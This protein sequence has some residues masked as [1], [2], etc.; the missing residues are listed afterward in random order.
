MRPTFG[1][2]AW[3][4][5]GLMS[6]TTHVAGDEPVSWGRRLRLPLL[7]GAPVLAAALALGFYLSGGRYQST[8]DAYV[9]NA[10]VDVSANIAWR[11]VSRP[12][13]DNQRVR[14]GQI[15]F[16]LDPAPN[17]AV[18]A[19]ALAAVG[20]ARQGLE[21]AKAVY[22]QRT[23][24]LGAAKTA[25]AYQ[26][27]ELQ[28]QKALARDG[29]SSQAQLDAQS[30]AVAAAAAQVAAAEKAKAAARA[31]L[32]AEPMSEVNPQVL[33]AR[34]ALDRAKL[35]QSY[36][37]VRAPQDGIVA[38]VDQLQVGAYVAAAQPL[39][40]LIPERAW[41][42]ANFKEDQLTYMRPGQDVALKVDAFPSLKLRGRLLSLSP[43]TGSS[44]AVLPAENASG[45]WVKVVQRVPVRIS[46]DNAPQD[47]ALSAGL[48][49]TARVDTGHRRS[50]LG[51]R[52]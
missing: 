6:E 9:A 34:A 31:Q 12:V 35:D 32:G 16:T 49:V 51:L 17:D 48:S 23:V 1:A 37:I 2:G 36:T 15:L 41:V 40:S 43:G 10:R 45:N 29:V 46:I 33:Q 38:K 21:A 5:R 24:E 19:Q 18:A 44:F 50:F 39:F 27:R 52:F 13:Q 25:L 20:V 4:R 14:A 28:R 42:I 47:L 11:V 3:R 7:I 8:D 22:D 30:Q 26:E